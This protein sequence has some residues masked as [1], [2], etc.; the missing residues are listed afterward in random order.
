[1]QIRDMLGIG[2]CLLSMV[3]HIDGQAKALQ[4][5]DMEASSPEV[6]QIESRHY[7]QY[8]YLPTVSVLSSR[9]DNQSKK[10]IITAFA[11]EEH[12]HIGGASV[13]PNAW[14]QE[15]AGNSS[16]IVIGRPYNR[17]SSLTSEQTFVFSDYE[18][19]VEK[20]LK[21]SGNLIAASPQVVVTRPGGVVDYGDK[22]FRAIDP[23]FQ[24]FHL[25]ERYLL[26][27]TR[28]PDSG[29]YKVGASG[30][31]LLKG[32]TVIAAKTHPRHALQ[33][34]REDDLVGILTEYVHRERAQK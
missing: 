5:K 32:G 6:R 27:L 9:P 24:L 12:R 4:V 34:D 3:Q 2:F 20:V 33:N 1:M 22:T 14:L 30:A 11:Q 31:F 17:I 21:D 25:G 18:F 16:A 28:L 8:A 13:D 23:E 15:L 19:R 10:E 29:T 26:F 7:G